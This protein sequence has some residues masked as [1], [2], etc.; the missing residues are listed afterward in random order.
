MDVQLLDILLIEDNPG[1]A[2]LIRELLLSS[3]GTTYRLDTATRLSEATARLSQQSFAAILLDLTLPDSSGL[4]TVLRV[5]A[6]AT[7]PII[8]LTGMDDEALALGAVRAGAQDYLIKSEVTSLLLSRA[9]YYAIERQRTATESRLHTAVFNSISEGIIITDAN[10]QIVALNPA[11]VDIS[12][13]AEEELLG[14]NPRM[15][16]SGRHDPQFY[17]AMWAALVASGYWQGEIWNR[18][19][20]GEI[21][22]EWLTINAVRD[23]AGH[24]T[25][26]VGAMIDITQ[27]KQAEDRLFFRATH[28]ALTGLPNRDHFHGRLAHAVARC[29]RDGGRLAVL[30][31]DLNRFKEINDTLGHSSGDIALQTTAQRLLKTIRKTDLVARLGGDEFVIVLESIPD[32]QICARIA[33]MIGLAVVEPMMFNGQPRTIGASIG[34]SLYPDDGRTGDTLIECADTAMYRAKQGGGGYTFF[35]SGNM[36]ALGGAP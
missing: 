8:V 1:D 14:N 24:V 17:Q 10:A 30:M 19:K 23:S 12:G 28:D 3:A 29:Q 32:P 25:H 31:I 7:A 9:I 6:V 11:V 33:E 21:Y 2:R 16:Q 22:P 4:D 13:Y 5:S 35:D 20:S 15:L 18:R 36:S 26:Y 34:I 27:Q